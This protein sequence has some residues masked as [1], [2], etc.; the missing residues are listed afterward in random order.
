MSVCGWQAGRRVNL[1]KGNK[2][3]ATT[4]HCPSKPVA[5]YSTN[6]TAPASCAGRGTPSDAAGG[7]SAHTTTALSPDGSRLLVSMDREKYVLDVAM[8]QWH[9][10]AV[11]PPRTLW[12][13]DNRTF[14]TFSGQGDDKVE[15]SAVDGGRTLASV[16]LRPTGTPRR[17]FEIIGSSPDGRFLVRCHSSGRDMRQAWLY[18]VATQTWQRVVDSP[19]CISVVGWSTQ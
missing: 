7:V 3:H 19:Y 13:Q 18:H 10:G 15:L 2:L 14:L 1:S 16:K 11:S 4:I 12:S 9:A 5:Q 8:G 6:Y 17:L